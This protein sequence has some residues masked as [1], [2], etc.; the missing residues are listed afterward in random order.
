MTFAASNIVN[1]SYQGTKACTLLVDDSKE[2]KTSTL[3]VN[4]TSTSPS[5]ASSSERS[6]QQ[7]SSGGMTKGDR[8]MLIDVFVR[9]RRDINS[10]GLEEL[11]GVAS[12]VSE[13]TTLHG[14]LDSNLFTTLVETSPSVTDDETSATS[15]KFEFDVST[16]DD[17]SDST[18][19]QFTT[20]VSTSSF[21]DSLS[22]STPV[23]SSSSSD[24]FYNTKSDDV[25]QSSTASLDQN[26]DADA[27]AVLEDELSRSTAEPS[28]STDASSS[29]P[30]EV[31]SD[32]DQ[33]VYA[34]KLGSPEVSDE[35]ASPDTDKFITT[36]T[37]RLEVSEI[38]YP[39]TDVNWSTSNNDGSEL[40]ENMYQSKG[41]G[42][43]FEHNDVNVDEVEIVKLKLEP[44]TSAEIYESPKS[45]SLNSY[46]EKHLEDL[47]V[48]TREDNDDPFEREIIDETEIKET[49]ESLESPKLDENRRQ[50]N[51]ARTQIVNLLPSTDA[52]KT[53]RIVVNVTISTEDPSSA[54]FQP[55]YVLSVYVPNDGSLPGI[56][57]DPVQSS[58]RV[59]ESDSKLADLIDVPPPPKP[60]TSPPPLIWG[61]ECI[62]SGSGE[63]DNSTDD[64]IDGIFED[65][66]TAID[67]VTDESLTTLSTGLTDGYD[68]VEG[69]TGYSS[70]YEPTLSTIQAPLC[71]QPLPPEPT[72]LILE[73]TVL[74]CVTQ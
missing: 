16:L 72:I 35:E 57:I 63:W 47:T 17:N 71:P 9:K 61:G 69:S 36:E 23:S 66:T 45:H 12:T 32:H 27:E 56:N 29:S 52:E 50:T 18:D 53:G 73:G 54:S 67:Q 3:D 65:G 5:Q 49:S 34:L 11:L 6:N 38:E 70:T 2:T 59:K 37:D 60:P 24:S 33:D 30:N 8:S 26:A 62:E 42:H 28:L 25:P 43:T 44:K 7:S 14:D 10:H 31:A 22:S 4:K 46:N 19:F 13:F 40:F 21:R 20:P 64:I 1:W 39:A 48:I 74:F 68:G 58:S 15:E 55:L 51:S 41:I